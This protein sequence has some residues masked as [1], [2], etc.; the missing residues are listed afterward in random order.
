M[1]IHCK[2]E[3]FDAIS[4]ARCEKNLSEKE[5]ILLLENK[6]NEGTKKRPRIE[7]VIEDD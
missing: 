1:I 2:Q 4:I 7:I 5:A 3:D 6:G